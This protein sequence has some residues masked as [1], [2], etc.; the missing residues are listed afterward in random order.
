MRVDG[1]L[2]LSL[3]QEVFLDELVLLQ[4]LQS[5]CHLCNLVSDEVDLSEGSSTD[6]FQKLKVIFAYLLAWLQQVLN[7][8]CIQLLI[9]A[10]FLVLISR[11]LIR[12]LHRGTRFFEHVVLFLHNFIISWPLDI[13]DY[14]VLRKILNLHWSSS[15]LQ[16]LAPIVE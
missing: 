1:G 8:A 10:I 12:G 9:S 15:A 2:T 14:M 6:D 3:D 4:D 13:A 7:F 16:H 5:I 11:M